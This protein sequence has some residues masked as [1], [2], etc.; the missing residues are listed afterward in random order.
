MAYFKNLTAIAVVFFL[1]SVCIASPNEKLHKECL[2]PTVMI[3][4][5]TGCG[6]GFVVRSEKVGKEYRNVILTCE[7]VVRD[8]KFPKVILPLYENWSS[9]VGVKTYES[10]IY[11][12]DEDKDIA[13]LLCLSKEKMP[14]AKLDFKSKLYIGSDILKIGCGLGDEPRIDFGQITSL[15]SL[16]CPKGTFRANIYIIPGDSGGPVFFNYKVIGLS[17]AVR[18][19][20]KGQLLPKF[21]YVVPI[22][23]IKTCGDSCKFVYNKICDLPVL[24]YYALKMRE[25]ILNSDRFKPT[26]WSPSPPP[27]LPCLHP[28]S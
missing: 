27:L 11:F 12:E 7:H 5:S 4:T 19:L 1:T 20:P 10:I 8:I 22:S 26:S 23:R 21:S 3:Q 25:Y 13:I 17:K 2:Y 16:F 18:T 14:I 9:L 15:K 6:T 28:A 24:P